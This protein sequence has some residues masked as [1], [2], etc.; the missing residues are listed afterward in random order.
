MLVVSSVVPNA[1]GSG[2]ELVL[3][4]HLKSNPE[5]ESKVVSWQRFPFRLKVI[6]KLREIGFQSLSRSMEC[7]SPVFP[8][9]KM[10]HDLIRSFRPDIVVTVAHGWWHIQARRVARKFKLPLVSFFQD[11]WPDFP[12]IPVAF[13]QSVE[14]Q[15][16]RTSR[17][18]TAAI[19]VCD[20]MR[21]E[22]G[23]RA[24]SLVIYPIPSFTRPRVWTPEFK[25]P[26]RL[27]YFGNLREYGPS[28]ENALRALEESDAVRLEVFGANPLWTPGA[29]DYFKSRGLYHPFI[30]SNQLMEAVRSYQA[31]L[32]VMSFEA[33]LRRRMTTSFP[34]KLV[35]AIQL[36]L[37]VVVWGPEYC[38]AVT[39]ARKGDRAL[40]V[41]DPNP[42][43][44]RETL[45]ELAASPSELRRLAK[46]ACDAAAGDFNY[47]RIQLQFMDALRRAKERGEGKA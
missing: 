32:V 33:A 43:A 22:L 7:L 26:L 45:E 28:I 11:W 19:C 16:R 12:E 27:V 38:S 29:E 24:N 3:H 35:D 44:L 41:S 42:L 10:V 46:S 14:R 40:C 31:V 5:I 9:N 2:G 13:R 37:P 15:F 20:Q 34:S 21:G 17:E 23:E 36:G 47:E 1:R 4:R 39:W 6:G 18:S 8:T 30:P 25:L